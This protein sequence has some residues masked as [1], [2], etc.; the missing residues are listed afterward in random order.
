MRTA[1]IIGLLFCSPLRADGPDRKDAV[2]A[3]LKKLQGV[4]EGY[5]VEGKGEHPDRG[6]VHLRL[7]IAG[8]KITAVDLGKGQRDMGRGTLRIDPSRPLKEIDAT[9]II[10]PGRR[11]RTYPGIYEVDGDTFKWCVDNRRT[12]RPTEFRTA[13]G[14]YLLILK[15]K[16]SAGGKP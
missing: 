12:S 9:G 14:K 15:R 3:E 5:A 6:P 1:L 7:M 13:G 10:L 4:W 16:K 2:R 8:T 11:K